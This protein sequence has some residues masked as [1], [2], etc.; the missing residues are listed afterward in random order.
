MATFVPPRDLQCRPGRQPEVPLSRPI[1][2]GNC[3][4]VHFTATVASCQTVAFH[5]VFG[6]WI[7]LQSTVRSAYTPAPGHP[8]GRAFPNCATP[9]PFRFESMAWR[10][11]RSN[12]PTLPLACHFLVKGPSICGKLATCGE[13]L[14]AAPRRTRTT[15]PPPSPRILAWVNAHFGISPRSWYNACVR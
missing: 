4:S 13:V 12:R 7:P 1:F 2:S 14:E 6:G 10:H 11:K 5:M 3:L 8:L 15:G 9:P